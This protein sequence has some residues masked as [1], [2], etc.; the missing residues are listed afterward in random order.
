[1]PRLFAKFNYFQNPFDPNAIDDAIKKRLFALKEL[2][3]TEENY[4]QDL[5]LIVN[6]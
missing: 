6:G 1:M 4:V 2:V 5:S 3:T